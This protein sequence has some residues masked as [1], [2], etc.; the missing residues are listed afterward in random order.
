MNGE[1]QLITGTLGGGKTLFAVEVIA[2]H[3]RKGGHVYTNI[4]IRPDAVR[5]W[6]ATQ[7][8]EFEADRLHVIPNA[9]IRTFHETLQR[10]EPD[11]RVYVVI[12][13][14]G[15]E[16]NS[17]DWKDTSRELLNFNVLV[18]KFDIFLVYIAQKPEM[19]DKQFRNLCQTQIDCRNLKHYRIAGHFPLPIPLLFRVHY[20][21]VWG[22]RIHT[23][24]QT[25]FVPKWV[26]G[27]YNSDAL[28]GDAAGKFATMARAT[29]SPLRR[30]PKLRLPSPPLPI[31]ILEVLTATCVAFLFSS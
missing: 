12:D 9:S 27:L 3:L 4:E 22:K 17:R 7:G 23:H 13:E 16:F 15:L 14:A 19:L 5:T 30:I 20:S 18:R 25:C 1:I 24:T 28:L 29:R 2:N 8:L 31:S 6:L 11:M 21:L 10:G 26:F